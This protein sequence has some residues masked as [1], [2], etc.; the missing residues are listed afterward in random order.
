MI[1]I[2]SLLALVA[3]VGCRTTPTPSKPSKPEVVIDIPGQLKVF[4]AANLIDITRDPSIQGV[5]LDA[6]AI[7]AKFKPPEGSTRGAPDAF[8]STEWSH[9]SDLNL[10]P[11]EARTLTVPVVKASLV[12][13]GGVWF[14]ASGPVEVTITAGGSSATGEVTPTPPG[15][16][17]VEARLTVDANTTATVLI[18]NGGGGS[19]TF[20]LAIGTTPLSSAP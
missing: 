5:R 20:Q 10:S 15:G 9:T 6:R 14:G 12:L 18:R 3:L 7:L 2:I 8:A 13:A 16:G 1:C 17:S 11:G 19:L 4:E